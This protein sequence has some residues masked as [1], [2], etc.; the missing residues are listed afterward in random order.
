MPLDLVIPLLALPADAPE[1]LSSARLPAVEK[2]I[3]RADGADEPAASA[4]EWIAREHGIAPPF[5]FAA[6]SLRGEGRDDAG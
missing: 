5:P 4:A 6:V 1:A 3:A 2:W